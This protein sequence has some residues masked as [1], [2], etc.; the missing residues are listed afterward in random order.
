MEFLIG[1]F[2]TDPELE[3]SKLIDFLTQSPEPP[4]S[5]RDMGINSSSTALDNN[6][7]PV[8]STSSLSESMI[9]IAIENV[10]EAGY[11]HIVSDETTINAPN[12]VSKMEM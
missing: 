8:Q 4:A 9:E 1:N 7:F 2:N 6:A 11:L 10:A 12:Q 5:P 3:I